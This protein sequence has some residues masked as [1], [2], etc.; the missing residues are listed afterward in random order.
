MSEQGDSGAARRIVRITV[1]TGRGRAET[2][3]A[4][5][6]FD[7]TPRES[8][9]RE[10]AKSVRQALAEAEAAASAARAREPSVLAEEDPDEFFDE[11]CKLVGWTKPGV[12]ERRE[13]LARLA[14]KLSDV[15]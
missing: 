1:E 15:R 6:V 10:I 5:V 8:A 13:V 9:D 4:R 3:I 11:V 2:A 12:P 7:L 14:E